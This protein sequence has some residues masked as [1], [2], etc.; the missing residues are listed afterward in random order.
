M[1]ITWIILQWVLVIFLA[2]VAAIIAYKMLIGQIDMT[3]LID[4]P[5]GKASLARFQFLLFTFAVVGIFVYL[6]F[7]AG[8]WVN[9]P[10]GVLALIG[11]SGASYVISKG[12]Q[13]QGNGD[14]DGTAKS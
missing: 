1:E 4:E 13:K 3:D 8:D 12:I 2:V 5:T 9:I 6:C 11:I 14:G 10:N 7:K